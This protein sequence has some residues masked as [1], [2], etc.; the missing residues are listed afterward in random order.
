MPLILSLRSKLEALA[1]VRARCR[2]PGPELVEGERRLPPAYRRAEPARV[3]D[4]GLAAWHPG[5][6]WLRSATLRLSTA[7]ALLPLLS[8]VSWS[9]SPGSAAPLGELFATVPGAPAV[10]QPA[11]TGM[12]VASGSELT[13]GVAPATLKLARGGQVRICPQT[14]LTIT[15]AGVGLMLGMGTGAIEID[16]RVGQGGGDVLITPDFNVR[17]VGPNLY[18]FVLGVSGRGDTCFKPLSGNAAGILL[19]EVMGPE[20]YGTSPNEAMVFSGG[21]LA[22]R[23]ALK[24]E[25][26]CP[27]PVLAPVLQAETQPAPSPRPSATASTS[28][29]P[30]PNRDPTAPLPPARPGETP[31]V[32]ETPFVFSAAARP[33]SVA[34]LQLSSLPNTVFVQ[35]E[36][37]PVVLIEKPAEVS[38]QDNGQKSAGQTKKEKEREQPKKES[39]G[40]MARLKGFF[41]S[42]FHR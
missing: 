23:G 11:G 6:W 28:P 34:R 41:G 9:Q 25:C 40:F 26:G 32:V 42:L 19:S 5:R 20:S 24:E 4:P 22:G 17:L 12:S 7:I 21:K 30:T 16:Y 10:A 36:P 33:A 29:E 8:L 31:V 35:D 13:A 15:D 18:H 1:G 2:N 3:G 14:N 38:A 37:E 27:S 39:K